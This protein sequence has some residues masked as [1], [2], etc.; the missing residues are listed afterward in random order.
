MDRDFQI[1]K[2][3]QFSLNPC[4]FNENTKQSLQSEDLS[5]T[6][7]TK[8]NDTS[9]NKSNFD[10]QILAKYFLQSLSKEI[11]KNIDSIFENININD[12]IQ[13]VF[14]QAEDNK[15]KS[16]RFLNKKVNRKV[17]QNTACLHSDKK[18]YAKVI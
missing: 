13:N 18:H 11:Q 10:K 15:I 12:I 1:V 2:R 14:K 16:K 17:H 3:E 5:S 8:E 6:K 4:M 9:R 7:H